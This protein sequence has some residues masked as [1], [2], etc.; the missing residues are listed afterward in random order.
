MGNLDQHKK[1]T[2]NEEPR[3]SEHQT[4]L[5]FFVALSECRQLLHTIRS[6]Q[7]E[8][9]IKSIL[10]LSQYPR[11][12]KT[13]LSS[14]LAEAAS[15]LLHQRVLIVDTAS[16]APTESPY[17]DYLRSNQSM[18]AGSDH[19][20]PG[21][22]DIVLAKQVRH[23][24]NSD[25]PKDTASQ[26]VAGVTSDFEVGAYLTAIREQYNLVLVDGCA[27]DLVGRD[28]LHPSILASHSDASLVVTSSRSIQRHSLTA[29][30]QLL[31]KNRICPLGF[32]HN[33]WDVT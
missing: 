30:K 31:T 33:Q 24:R 4:T 32:V 19:K 25:F 1:G 13:F 5:R 17:R 29:M 6:R 18:T 28:S 12:G 8:M 26:G 27:L 21:S 15:S 3:P 11:E 9:G 20:T 7:S 2:N 14:V 16:T 10:I 23:N 22:I